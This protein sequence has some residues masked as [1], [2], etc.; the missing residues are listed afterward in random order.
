M[1][2]ISDA[3][4][5]IA[6]LVVTISEV[7]VSVSAVVAAI[8]AT[9][10]SRSALTSSSSYVSAYLVMP[11]FPDPQNMKNGSAINL[12]VKTIVQLY[13]SD[14]TIRSPLPEPC[15]GLIIN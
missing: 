7:V 11:S 12:L 9:N 1:L 4:I 2:A 10:V 13:A 15:N 14:M 5:S 3:V 6:D 8:E